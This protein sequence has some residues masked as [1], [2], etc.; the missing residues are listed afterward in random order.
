MIGVNPYKDWKRIHKKIS[1]MKNFF[2]GDLGK[3]DKSMPAQVQDAVA[4]VIGSFYRGEHPEMVKFL[5]E[6]MCRVFV[7]ILNKVYGTTHTIS[8]GIWMTILF[9]SLC[10]RFLTAMKYYRACI[11]AGR[12]PTVAEY[13]KI[14]D[15]V[16]GDDKLNAVPDELKD[17]FNAETMKEFFESIGMEFTFGDKTPVTQ[18]FQPMEDLTF[19]KRSFTFHP[20]LGEIMCPL[21][22]DTITNSI[23]WLDKR[24]DPDVVLDGKISCFQREIYLHPDDVR[25]SL[26]KNLADKCA[27]SDVPYVNLP[28][29]YLKYVFTYECDT[30]YEEYK[31]N[32]DKNF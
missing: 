10:N 2:G 31:S 9:N 13:H 17:I 4:A 19:L 11:K 5:M 7:A 23:M 20:I 28:D 1:K 26:L 3:W 16:C 32:F 25:E 8:S 21:S 15:F 18:P 14:V 27:T 29:E 6:Y 24:K 12:L 22:L 30:I